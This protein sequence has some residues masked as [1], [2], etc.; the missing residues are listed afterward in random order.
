[1]DK[2]TR[3]KH[4]NTKRTAPI[5]TKMKLNVHFGCVDAPGLLFAS[6]ENTVELRACEGHEHGWRGGLHHVAKNKACCLMRL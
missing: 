3:Q 5:A 6:D 4:V 1:M 2:A